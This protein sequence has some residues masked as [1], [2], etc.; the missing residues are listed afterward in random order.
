MTC[1]I[2]GAIGALR[3]AGVTHPIFQAV[4]HLFV[5]GL[6]GSAV[7]HASEQAW[8]AYAFSKDRDAKLA[9]ALTVLEAAC[10]VVSRMS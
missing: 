10:F 1:V 7:R 5:G 3:I 4:A 9:F 2:A 6:F 8:F